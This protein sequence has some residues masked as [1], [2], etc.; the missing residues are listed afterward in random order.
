MLGL[1]GTCGDLLGYKPVHVPQG[2][3][4]DHI[5]RLKD[6]SLLKQGFPKPS[7]LCR[8][9]CVGGVRLSPKGNMS[10]EHEVNRAILTAK[11]LLAPEILPAKTIFINKRCY[12]IER[13]NV[14]QPLFLRIK[15]A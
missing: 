5:N 14:H 13:L 12:E 8:M 4:I 10:E 2:H 7:F 9:S 1:V 6:S 11:K 3:H 15:L